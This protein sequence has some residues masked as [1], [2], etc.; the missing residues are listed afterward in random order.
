MKTIKT[1]L[2]Y[3]KKHIDVL[4]SE[5]LLSFVLDKKNTY[6][7]THGDESVA[8]ENIVSFLE[9]VKKRK[10]KYSISS[11]LGYKNF[12]GKDFY[13]DNTVLTPRPETEVLVETA[14]NYINQNNITT[15][16][17]IGTGS[18][19]I[20]ITLACFLNNDEK[21]IASDFSEKALNMA[22]KNAKKNKQEKIE[23]IFS[24]LL[25]NINI[26]FPESTSIVTNLPYV[27]SSDIL[28]EEVLKGD[29][30]EA[31][32]SGKDGLCHYNELFKTLPKNINSVF[33]EFHP[34]QKNLIKNIV[35]NYHP[36]LNI[37][38]FKDFSNKERFGFLGI[39]NITF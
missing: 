6:F 16:L 34:P 19:C 24:D 10:E 11:L 18:G 33:F 29:P 38:F 36:E 20:A 14:L 8:E 1:L 39:K 23:F 35:G 31:L 17:D 3:A 26:T 4:D 21:I 5:I 13:V 2:S 15:V 22:K 30:K 28:E 32:F 27:P 7:I 9:L 12:Y 25:K 37:T